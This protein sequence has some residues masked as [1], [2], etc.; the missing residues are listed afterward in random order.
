MVRLRFAA[1]LITVLAF[2]VSYIAAATRHVTDTNAARRPR[3]SAPAGENAKLRV[4]FLADE[5]PSELTKEVFEA[6]TASIKLSL[7]GEAMN[8]QRDFV[9]GAVS[10]YLA[11]QSGEHEVSLTVENSD[12]VFN[13]QAL[14]LAA[15]TY[16]L[17]ITGDANGFGLETVKDTLGILDDNQAGAV[18]VNVSSEDLWITGLGS[19]LF[20]TEKLRP[21]LVS[22]RYDL[23][24]G[25]RLINVGGS[26]SDASFSFKLRSFS[27]AAQLVIFHNDSDVYVLRRGSRGVVKPA[28]KVGI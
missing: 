5:L 22:A 6:S 11:V 12:Q 24:A 15:T 23:R 21:G 1:S 27:K 18:L 13:A 26:P 10:E 3:L 28:R 20:D 25:R 14:T 19:A 4:M 17:I 16:T 9:H 8:F 7:D 2:A